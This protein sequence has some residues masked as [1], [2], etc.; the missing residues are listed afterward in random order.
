M[1][2]LLYR[3]TDDGVFDDLAKISDHF[4]KIS[5][6]SPKRYPKI[7]EDFRGRPEDV[8][9]LDSVLGLYMVRRCSLNRSFKRRFVSPMHRKLQSLH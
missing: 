6:D 1:F 4:S 7:V 2:L 8:V 5:E 3:Q 9:G